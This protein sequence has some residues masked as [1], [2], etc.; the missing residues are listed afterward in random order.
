M[1]STSSAK[2]T[3]DNLRGLQFNLTISDEWFSLTT[4]AKIAACVEIRERAL[5]GIGELNVYDPETPCLR[6]G[7]RN[8]RPIHT[9]SAKRIGLD[10]YQHSGPR[11]LTTEM[12]L[13]LV[14]RP[15]WVA[16]ET[17]PR[18]ITHSNYESLPH[19]KFNDLGEK[20]ANAG[21]VHV[22]NG[23]HRIQGLRY[24]YGMAKAELER[25]REIIEAQEEGKQSDDD[26]AAYDS[27]LEK[28]EKLKTW[29]CNIWNLDVIEGD[30]KGTLLIDLLSQN[31]DTVE[32]ATTEEDRLAPIYQQLLGLEMKEGWRPRLWRA[33]PLPSDIGMSH[34]RKP[35]ELMLQIHANKAKVDRISRDPR[36]TRGMMEMTRMGKYYRD[37]SGFN[38][39]HLSLNT[40]KATSSYLWTYIQAQN[41]LLGL[42]FSPS[43]LDAEFPY[44]EFF[45]LIVKLG[46][47]KTATSRDGLMARADELIAE[48]KAMF[49]DQQEA[50]PDLEHFYTM[51]FWTLVE[52]AELEAGLVTLGKGKKKREK[53]YPDDVFQVFTLIQKERYMTYVAKIREAIQHVISRVEALLVPHVKISALKRFDLLFSGHLHDIHP[54][55]MTTGLVSKFEDLSEKYSDCFREIHAWVDPISIYLLE[56]PKDYPADRSYLLF[57]SFSR[58]KLLKRHWNVELLFTFDVMSDLVPHFA[59][60]MIEMETD[61]KFIHIPQ[62]E[63]AKLPR[64]FFEKVGI[65][66]EAKG[67]GKAKAS[68][69][70]PPYPPR[71]SNHNN[72]IFASG[73]L[74]LTW[75]LE[76]DNFKLC[77][78]VF[79]TW[80]SA[81]EISLRRESRSSK[82]N[83]HRAMS[84]YPLISISEGT[85][86]NVNRLSSKWKIAMLLYMIHD[87]RCHKPLIQT[88]GITALLYTTLADRISNF[89]IDPQRF[90]F[91]IGHAKA[92]RSQGSKY[93]ENPSAFVRNLQGLPEESEDE[94]DESDT[95]LSH[96]KLARKQHQASILSMRKAFQNLPWIHYRNNITNDIDDDL[97]EAWNDFES[98][99]HRFSIVHAVNSVLSDEQKFGDRQKV[100][101]YDED[102][103]SGQWI[104]SSGRSLRPRFYKGSAHL[105]SIYYYYL[106]PSRQG[107]APPAF[108]KGHRDF[109]YIFDSA[110]EEDNKSYDSVTSSDASSD[111]SYAPKRR[112]KSKR[113]EDTE[114]AGGD[115]SP[116]DGAADEP[117][118]PQ[119]PPSGKQ[120]MSS[121]RSRQPASTSNSPSS[122]LAVKRGRI[123]EPQTDSNPPRQS[124]RLK[125]A[126]SETVD[127]QRTGR[128][129]RSKSRKGPKGDSDELVANTGGLK[130][131]GY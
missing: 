90:D 29:P 35:T 80:N 120:A 72:G 106:D 43:E 117:E 39:N 3:V 37:W 18:Q 44:E 5:I 12:A 86:S 4:D 56:W 81:T 114:M 54:I 116:H 60:W 95:P 36:T 77:H 111:K 9:P 128:S 94:P 13:N 92:A 88:K 89:G 58:D 69:A 47:A 6:L 83:V 24:A 27:E 16:N 113:Q 123:T 97:I 20:A 131:L 78:D 105:F 45:T 107:K 55:L 119:T 64:G 15:S 46:R 14:I 93:L 127:A 67:K 99:L 1:A 34:H 7:G 8:A 19:I 82:Q 70:N 57:D 31:K 87:A 79:H 100:T 59:N 49:I 124:S 73:P 125:A 103:S 63:T 65:Y 10:V 98:A 109:A 121:K 102:L 115:E 38:I 33:T 42:I 53:V 40:I 62:R 85:G 112:K 2:P 104:P 66:A 76:C 71:P 108:L 68:E 22:I 21:Q 52:K 126:T 101:I 30:G 48:F 51:E 129:A 75:E 17:W 25:L 118:P 23:Q 61:P 11:R 32:V 41:E 96:Y 110:G 84:V 28:L 91:V 122:Q 26:K 50:L 130:K 74:A